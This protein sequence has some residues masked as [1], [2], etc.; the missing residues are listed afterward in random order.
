MA[1]IKSAQD[2]TERRVAIKAQPF[3]LSDFC[4]DSR[5][6]ESDYCRVHRRGMNETTVQ[7]FGRG[8]TIIVEGN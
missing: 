3:C 4:T 6:M 7:G 8:R 5:S 2:R 1:K